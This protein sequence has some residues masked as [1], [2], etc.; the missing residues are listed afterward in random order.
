M[1]R[2][3]PVS[4]T[5]YLDILPRDDDGMGFALELEPFRGQYV[6]I[7]IE[8]ANDGRCPVDPSPTPGGHRGTGEKGGG[9]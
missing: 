1:K 3:L 5:C 6:K 8:A 7:T 9:E 4:F 2:K